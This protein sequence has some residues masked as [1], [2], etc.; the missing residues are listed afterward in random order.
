MACPGDAELASFVSGQLPPAEEAEVSAHLEQCAS[1]PGRAAEQAEIDL[2]RTAA[3]SSQPRGDGFVAGEGATLGRY[4]VLDCLGRGGMGEVYKA[5]DPELDRA[6]ALKLMRADDS[7]SGAGGR[8]RML[9]EAKAMARLSHPNVVAVHDAG[10]VGHEVFIAMDLVDGT[11]LDEWL[12]ARPRGWREVVAA[13]IAAGS[14]LGAAH[15]KGIVH[16]DFKPQN[17][18]VDREGRVFVTD[19]GLAVAQTSGAGATP[20]EIAGTPAYMSPEQFAG[21]SLDARTDQFSF[22]VALYEGLYAERP[23]RGRGKALAEAIKSGVVG[24]APRDA[25][26]PAWLRKILLKGLSVDPAQRFASMDALLAALL[27]DP[28]AKRRKVALAVAPRCWPA[29]MAAAASC[30]R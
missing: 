18:L 9:R 4:S 16:R 23:F 17:V 5:Y 3:S 27:D 26:V 25:K 30:A 19:F 28:L 15:A 22:C 2:A 14:G 24:A 11:T 13:F 1:C 6:V 21:R 12:R 7:A 20:E 29:S 8:G 10:V